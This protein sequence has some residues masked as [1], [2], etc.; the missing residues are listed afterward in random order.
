VANEFCSSHTIMWPQRLPAPASVYMKKLRALR[1]ASANPAD[2][3]TEVRSNAFRLRAIS[4]ARKELP[5]AKGKAV[6]RLVSAGD[7]PP[8]SSGCRPASW[9]SQP[10]AR[11][12][13]TSLPGVAAV[14]VAEVTGP[15][16]SY[17]RGGE[18]CGRASIN[19]GRWISRPL[20]L[21]I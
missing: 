3:A 14:A 20:I 10:V 19:F 12:G 13:R 1:R 17:F 9:S 8:G 11:L 18:V 2:T 16:Y 15:R 7:A 21:E 6:P 5:A 4:V